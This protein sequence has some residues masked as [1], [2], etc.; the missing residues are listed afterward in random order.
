MKHAGPEALDKLEPVLAE[1]RK[2]SSLRER[3]RGSFY[4]GSVGFLHFH[5]GPAGFFADLKVDGE[6]IRMPANNPGEIA[7]LIRAAAKAIRS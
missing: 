3:K 2:I 1:I 4:Q 6:F 5:E 7:K